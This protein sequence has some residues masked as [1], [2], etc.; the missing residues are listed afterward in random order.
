MYKCDQTILDNLVIPEAIDRN[1]LVSLILV[2]TGNLETFYPDPYFFKQFVGIWSQSRLTIWSKLWDTTQYEY[3]P[4]HNYDRTEER[5]YQYMTV[6]DETHNGT[7]DDT[8]NKTAT[9]LE[10]VDENTTENVTDD[11]GVTGTDTANKTS[12]TTG[13]TTDTTS[14]TV[15]EEVSAF[16]ALTYQPEKKT[17]TNNNYTSNVTGHVDN[18]ETST[19]KRDTV[20]T[21]D[22]EG[23]RTVGRDVTDTEQVA[24]NE[25]TSGKIDKTTTHTYSEKL[26]AYGNIGV[27]TTQQ[28]IES[29]RELVKFNLYEYIAEEFAKEFC[30]LVY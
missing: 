9:V 18:D 29:E 24:D 5:N 7:R 19:T 3:N 21:R 22:T 1:M 15:E 6:E 4:I 16:N 20:E 26:R 11:T 2:R 10:N 13:T 25:K 14:G 23:T 8:L 12:D 28:M 27:T 17:T 30:L